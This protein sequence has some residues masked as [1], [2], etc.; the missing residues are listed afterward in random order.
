MT[1]SRS[2]RCLVVPLSRHF[3]GRHYL[4]RGQAQKV[5]KVLLDESQ[6]LDLWLWLPFLDAG[7]RG[8]LHQQ[9]NLPLVITGDQS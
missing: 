2:I 5:G 8:G 6:L 1:E 7:A 3:T 4:A 9:T